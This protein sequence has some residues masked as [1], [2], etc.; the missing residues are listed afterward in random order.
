MAW[1]KI[2]VNHRF[3]K[4]LIAKNINAKLHDE[5]CQCRKEV[6]ES[7]QKS[8]KDAY[9][10]VYIV[11][12][13]NKQSEKAENTGSNLRSNHRSCRRNEDSDDDLE[14]D[15]DLDDTKTVTCIY[16][17]KVSLKTRNSKPLL[18]FEG[19]TKKKKKDTVKS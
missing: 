15:T 14:F 12:L 9:H 17:L 10:I 3:D 13:F 4:G 1:E 16:M 8:L 5:V 7:L 18:T 2:F 6:L 11:A 19:F